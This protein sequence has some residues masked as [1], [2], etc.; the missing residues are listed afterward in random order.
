MGCDN[1]QNTIT[2]C[3]SIIRAGKRRLMFC[4]ALA[5]TNN[6]TSQAKKSHDSNATI[7][8]TLDIENSRRTLGLFFLDVIPDSICEEGRCL[9]KE[10]FDASIK[11]IHSTNALDWLLASP[12]VDQ[13]AN[14]LLDYQHNLLWAP[15]RQHEQVSTPPSQPNWEASTDEGMEQHA[16][17][18]IMS[19][20]RAAQM[21]QPPE[22]STDS[23]QW[24]QGTMPRGVSINERQF[25]N[26]QS[27]GTES[28]PVSNY[29]MN[30]NHL[31]WFHGATDVAGET[32]NHQMQ[33]GS[34]TDT[35]NPMEAQSANIV[36]EM[37]NYRM[38]PG[39]F[40]LNTSCQHDPVSTETPNYH[41]NAN[42]FIWYS[43]ER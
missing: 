28:Q 18:N 15:Q 20:L 26:R 16:A 11:A 35:M 8:E 24:G 5:R 14:L 1:A 33:P 7:E 32:N 38:Q 6:N 34:F 17:S 31:L 39:L 30:V 37:N 41:L 21:T 19:L 22:D 40:N 9:R 4:D 27:L 42:E 12:I 23:T 29:R 43:S 25:D 3:R 13:L 2:S 36:G 10:D